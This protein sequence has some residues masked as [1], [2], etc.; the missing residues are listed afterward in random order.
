MPFLLF[1]YVN[2]KG[3]N[4]FK[5]WSKTLQKK[6]L[7]KLN[8]KLDMLVCHGDDFTPHLFT[9]TSI[10]NIKKLRVRGSVQLRP[11]LCHGPIN[12]NLEYTLL[13]GAKEIGDKWLPKDAPQKALNKMLEVTEDPD[14][15][16]R[17]HERVN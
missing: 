3:E 4:E 15:K 13:M 6:E 5:E 1:D 2:D 9:D 14:K 12:N 10:S 17:E 7:A 11:L 8:Q 16:R